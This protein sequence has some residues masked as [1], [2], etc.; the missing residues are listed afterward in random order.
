MQLSEAEAAGK[1]TALPR[2]MSLAGGVYESI[3]AQLMSL[4]IAP[5]ARITVDNL[6]KKLNV[7]QTPIREALGRLEGEGLV[8]RTHLVGYH[9]APQITKKQF[10]ELYE[11][12]LLL[13]PDTVANSARLISDAQLADLR[14]LARVMAEI[15][16]NEETLRYSNFARKDADFHDR[17]LGISGNNLIRETLRVQHTHF[18]IFRLMYHWRVTAEA[19]D[20]HEAILDALA[21]RNP[22]AA[23]LAMQ[24]HIERS[25]IRL[26]PA[27]D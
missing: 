1:S 7:S 10:E 9:A 21:G 17:I 4:E 6:V 3:F 14:A 12:R 23:R 24:T 5:G 22:E 16:G 20:E 19:L 8:T 11:L 2:P 18:R 13:E 27:F 25:K 15:G 26:M